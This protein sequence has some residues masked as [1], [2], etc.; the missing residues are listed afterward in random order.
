[1][2]WPRI[3]DRIGTMGVFIIKVTKMALELGALHGSTVSLI[4]R[5]VRRGT[6]WVPPESRRMPPTK[7]Q[8][9]LR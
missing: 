7:S 5:R 1:M 8:K 2:K 4:I 3:R 6:H 9:N